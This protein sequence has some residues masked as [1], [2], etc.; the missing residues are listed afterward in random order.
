MIFNVRFPRRLSVEQNEAIGKES[1][2]AQNT[3]LP[4]T[5]G[6]K[7]LRVSNINFHPVERVGLKCEVSLNPVLKLETIVTDFGDDSNQA[8]RIRFVSVFV[9]V[10]IRIFRIFFR[11]RIRIEF[12]CDKEEYSYS[13]SYSYFY[14]NC[15]CIRKNS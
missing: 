11:I 14:T 5:G 2:F 7:F 13:N 10:F 12:D 9:S 1:F 6:H 3:L 4:V 8:C 15:I